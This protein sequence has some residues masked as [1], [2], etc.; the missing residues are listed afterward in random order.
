MN[1]PRYVVK[2]D[3]ERGA[4][5]ARE[6]IAAELRFIT[7]AERALGGTEGVAFAYR[8]SVAAA[9][10]Q[11]NEIDGGTV[12]LARRWIEAYKAAAGK[13]LDGLYGIEE[14]NFTIRLH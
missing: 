11:A 8:A 12:A 5:T 2:L 1:E 6:R 9:D 13:A 3:C 4:I 10:A 14:P 7:A